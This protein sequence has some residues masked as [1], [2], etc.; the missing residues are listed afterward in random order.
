MEYITLTTSAAEWFETT[1]MPYILTFATTLGALLTA[2]APLIAAVKRLKR[3]SDTVMKCNASVVADNA[4]LKAENSTYRAQIAETNERVE[5]IEHALK[6]ALLNDRDL[7]ERGYAD[8][9]SAVFDGK[10]SKDN[11]G[12]DTDESGRESASETDAKD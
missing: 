6:I 1:A 8:M 3:N 5:R 2:L 10:V 12:G 4:A 9:I 11:E 7:V